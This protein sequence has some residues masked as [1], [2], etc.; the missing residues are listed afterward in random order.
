MS[1]LGQAALLALVFVLG[2]A[3]AFGQANVNGDLA[4]LRAWRLGNA[5]WF[6]L[7]VAGATLAANGLKLV[8]RVDRPHTLG[9]SYSFPSGHATTVFAVAAVLARAY[10]P[11][12]PLFAAVALFGEAVANHAR[13]H[14]RRTDPGHTCRNP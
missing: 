14:G 3:L 12:G 4:R 5:V 9:S 8:F 6:W 11:V 2:P 7:L 13:N 10:P 1:K